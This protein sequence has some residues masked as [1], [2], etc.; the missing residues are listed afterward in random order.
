VKHS[1]HALRPCDD[2]PCPDAR[3]RFARLIPS[4]VTQ[5][6]KKGVTKPECSRIVLIV[7]MARLWRTAVSLDIFISTLTDNE[8]EK[9][10]RAVV[11]R[12]FRGIAVDQTGNYWNLQTPQRERTSVTVS[13]DEEATIS[14]FSANRPPAYRSFPEFWNAMFEVLRETHTVLFWPACETVS[15]CCVANPKM[16][17]HVSGDIVAA[18]GEPAFVSSGA[19][20]EA[21][22]TRS[23][24]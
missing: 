19:E 13:V 11:E 21:A 20:I 9:F 12:A 17:A 14:A 3:Q 6:H 24:S 18:L 23:F 1:G 5:S 2:Q 15:H 10:D 7:G 8:I 16:A 22:M 4:D